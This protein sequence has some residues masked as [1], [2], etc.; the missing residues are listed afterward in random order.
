MVLNKRQRGNVGEELAAK[1]LIKK[2][3]R[4]LERNYRFEHGEIDLIAEDGDELVFVEVK[5]RTSKLFGEPEDSITEKKEGHVRDTAEGYLYEKG[6][7]NRTC[8]FD[9]IAVDF[10][11]GVADIR[12]TKDAF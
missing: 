3:Y 6:I 1:F 7:E 10:H 4:I 8:R 11:N 2:G 12:H 5:A 9:V